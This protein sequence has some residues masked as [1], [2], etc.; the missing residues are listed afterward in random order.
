MNINVM[1][2]SQIYSNSV[3]LN[4]LVAQLKFL[5]IDIVSSWCDHLVIF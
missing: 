5:E 4:G 3:V 1:S 2:Y